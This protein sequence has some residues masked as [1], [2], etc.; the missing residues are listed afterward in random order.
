[1]VKKWSDSKSTQKNCKNTCDIPLD[2]P[3]KTILNDAIHMSEK[4]FSDF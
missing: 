1:M 3:L 2:S 4:N